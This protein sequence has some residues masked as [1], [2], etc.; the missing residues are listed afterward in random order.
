MQINFI[1]IFFRVYDDNSRY[2]EQIRFN[3]TYVYK[4][5]FKDIFR[6]IKESVKN[7]FDY[8]YGT[9]N[10]YIFMPIGNTIKSIL[11]KSK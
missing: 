4:E 7:G 5:T 8:F 3:N 1:V 6:D 2:T 10:D 9:I 11:P